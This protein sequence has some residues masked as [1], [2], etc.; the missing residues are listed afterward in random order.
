[1][2]TTVAHVCGVDLPKSLEILTNTDLADITLDRVIPLESLVD[3]GILALA[4]GRAKGK[5]IVNPQT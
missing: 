2:T 1:M 5:V 3:E 4:D